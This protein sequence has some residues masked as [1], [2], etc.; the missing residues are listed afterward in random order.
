MCSIGVGIGGGSHVDHE[1]ESESESK[2]ESKR[3]VEG[4]WDEF[5]RKEQCRRLIKRYNQV[6]EYIQCNDFP[7]SEVREYERTLKRI[8]SER[9]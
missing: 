8:I 6:L 5:E 9:C 3:T 4:D 1:S 2:S 7:E